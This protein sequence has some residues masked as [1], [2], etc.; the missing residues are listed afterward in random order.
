M[1]ISHVK[2]LRILF[3]LLACCATA[4]YSFA[5]EAE[6]ECQG[7]EY[8]RGK[9]AICLPLG[10]LSFADKLVSFTPGEKPSLP[11]FD[12][13]ETALGEPNYK[14]TRSPDFVSLGCNGEL[15]LQFTDNVLIDVPGMD[16][17]IFEVG[18]FV[19]KT[20]LFISNDASQWIAIGEIEGARSE[21]DIQPYVDSGDTFAYVKLVNAGK[22]CGGKHS[23]ADIDAVA[24][25]GAE[26]RLSLNS[27]VLFD[28]GKAELKP[29][30][31]TELDALIDAI[32]KYGTDAR[33]TIEGHTDAT[34]SDSDNQRLSELRAAS[35]RGYLVDKKALPADQMATKGHGETRPIADNETEEGRALN[36]RVDILVKPG[37]SRSL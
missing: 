16:L 20:E 30:A 29:E 34:G 19:E 9:R 14:N 1:H 3:C 33:V 21:I 17:Y 26:I 11:P 28:V 32:A 22:S 25:V 13:G 2:L 24:A 31:N 10:A 18:P 37:I 4:H 23:G 6:I 15:V 7:T 5:V 12:N 27:A 35:V 36:R 8:G